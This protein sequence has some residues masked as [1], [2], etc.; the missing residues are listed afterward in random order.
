[1]ARLIGNIIGYNNW[2]DIPFYVLPIP[3]HLAGIVNGLTYLL[4]EISSTTYLSQLHTDLTTKTIYMRTR[5]FFS[6]FVLIIS[7]AS[8]SKMGSN[9]PAG[10]G[11]TTAKAGGGGSGTGGGTGTNTCNNSLADAETIAIFPSDNEWH[12]DISSAPVDLYSTQILAH[13]ATT[14]LHP[15]FGSGQIGGLPFGIPASVVC[16]SQPKV[17][18]VFRQNSVD[19]NFGNESDP[20]PYPIPLN[21][22]VE[23]GGDAHVIVVDKDAHKLYELYNA[24]V[25]GDH[26]EASSGA[27]FDLNSN[28]YRPDGWT[29]ADAA[30]LPIFPGLIRYDELVK[31]TIDHAIRFT[32]G[33]ANTL[34]SYI[35]PARHAGNGSGTVHNALPFGARLRLKASVNISTYPAHLQTILKAFKKYGIILAD[36]GSNMYISGTQDGRWDNDELS[37]LRNI[38]A[39]DFEV[40]NI[41]N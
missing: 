8:C 25:N 34:S 16:A 37:N 2:P 35:L 20:G 29:S 17:A 9:P 36:I 24:S 38:K 7:L 39:S 11:D 4:T 12:K 23:S 3:K 28:A 31:G 19:G 40:I 41:G 5:M 1:M 18:I 10:S 6:L 22:P 30:G 14:G 13:Y 27:V 21:A 26:W 15:D 33:R 32:L